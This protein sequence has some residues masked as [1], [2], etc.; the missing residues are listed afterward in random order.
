MTNREGATPAPDGV[1]F[2]PPPQAGQ[3]L[4]MEFRASSVFPLVGFASV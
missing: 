3:V 1:G 2:P 4:Q